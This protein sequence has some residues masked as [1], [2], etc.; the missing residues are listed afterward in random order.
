MIALPILSITVSRISPPIDSYATLMPFE[1]SLLTSSSNVFSDFLIFVKL[2]T[3]V[4]PIDFKNSSFVSV[5][6]V[7]T[8]FSIPAWCI[9]W[10]ANLKIY[11]SKSDFRLPILDYLASST[12]GGSDQ[13]SFWRVFHFRFPVNSIEFKCNWCC[14]SRWRNCQYSWVR[15]GYF[16]GFDGQVCRIG[17]GLIYEI[18][19]ELIPSQKLTPTCIIFRWNHILSWHSVI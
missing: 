8:M 15:F 2:I 10:T 12:C 16:K 5:E 3:W 19:C 18:S 17:H 14:K 7:P 6:Q 13:T 9:S 1:Q 11:K 4:A